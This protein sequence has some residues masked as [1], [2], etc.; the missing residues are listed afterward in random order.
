MQNNKFRVI[1]MGTPKIAAVC[2]AAIL[3]R[4]DVDVVGVVC[5]PDKPVG[6]KKQIIF[7]EVKSL[8]LSNNLLVLQD[9]KVANLYDKIDNLKPDLI[10]TCAFGQFV[11]ESILNLPKYKC[12]NLHASLLPKLRGGAPIQWAIINEFKETGFSLMYMDKKMDAG[13]IIKQYPI[14][15]SHNTTYESLY[16][17]L[18]NL[19]ETIIADDFQILFDPNTKG[20]QQQEKE[21]TFGYN[22]T[23]EDEKINWNNPAHKIDALVRGLYRTPCAYSNFEN[24]NI[25]IL[26]TEVLDKF[27]NAIPG[28]IVNVSKNGIE[29]ATTEK[30]I[31]IKVLQLPGKNPC[32]ISQIINGNHQFTIGKRFN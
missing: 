6:R 31:N 27:P 3:K 11:P 30:V 8:A 10:F 22:I 4:N 25:K 16:D 32:T 5:Q 18:C 28:N 15:I 2:L 29:V 1:F 12:V 9:E 21:V 24:M 19:A 20:F 7:S 23:R 17:E 14:E 13:D 26:E